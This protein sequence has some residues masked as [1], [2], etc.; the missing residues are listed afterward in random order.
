MPEVEPRQF[1]SSAPDEP[2]KTRRQLIRRCLLELGLGFGIASVLMVLAA[3]RRGM[4]DEDLVIVLVGLSLAGSL[5]LAVVDYRSGMRRIRASAQGLSADVHALA[6][7][8]LD[9][10]PGVLVDRTADVP[11][12][13]APGLRLV[14]LFEERTLNVHRAILFLHGRKTS[15]P[16][17]ELAELKNALTGWAREYLGGNRLRELGVGVVIEGRLPAVSFEELV[18]FVDGTAK[19]VIIQWLIWDDAEARRTLAVH[20]PVQGRS[21]PCF[22]RILRDLAQS[23]R[24]VELRVRDREGAYR[25][26]M[27]LHERLSWF[28]SLPARIILAALAGLL[29]TVLRP[30]TDDHANTETERLPMAQNRRADVD[31]ALKDVDF[32][33]TKHQLVLETTMGN[34]TLDLWPDVA[35][36]HVRNIVGLAK[37][38]YYDGVIFHRVIKGF[39]IQG[40]DPQGTGTGGPGYQIKAEFNDRP[41][42]PGTL[43]M[44]R[45]SDPNSAGSQFFICLERVPHLDRQYTAFGKTADAASLD[46]VRKIGDVKTGAQDRPTQEV[47]ITKARVI[48]TAR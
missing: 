11:E 38:G 22:Q 3:L 10:Y 43:S 41:H 19:S 12:A 15:P 7:T 5:L 30:G 23:G 4:L 47:K 48:E 1:L 20:M 32:S 40:G 44:A 24:A 27:R 6:R 46:V 21:T 26:A 29:R 28:R 18:P 36:G 31:A 25:A 16:E 9:V 2:P 34:I 35:P 14:W 8:C 39:M 17:I 37:I 13:V 42:E 45:T 33:K